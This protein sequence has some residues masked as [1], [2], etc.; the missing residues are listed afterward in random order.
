MSRTETISR[1]AKEI[2]D[3]VKSVIT[4]LDDDIRL[5]IIVLLL[6][7]SRLSFTQLKNELNIRSNSSL[8]HHLAILQDGGLIENRVVL[9]KDKHTSYYRALDLAIE[10]L[11]SL[12]D[13]ILSPSSRSVDSLPI[14][15]ATSST[16][17]IGAPTPS[18]TYCP[19]ERETSPIPPLIYNRSESSG[20]RP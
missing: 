8:S 13:V 16:K 10:I 1:Y 7:K 15:L 9:G 18:Q 3:E 17:T 20:V 4:G 12:F 11:R 5:A 19:T 14:S 6:K 2:P